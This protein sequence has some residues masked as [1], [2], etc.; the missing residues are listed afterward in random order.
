MV[1][2]GYSAVS[3]IS[4][5]YQYLLQ[6]LPHYIDEVE[7]VILG[8]D[9][10]RQ[11]WNGN[12]FVVP[13]K[14]FQQ[15]EAMDPAGKIRIVE[16]N[17]YIPNFTALENDTRERNFLSN[18]VKP[19]NW[20]ISLDAD[21]VILNPAALKDYLASLS[22]TDVSVLAQAVTVF[23]RLPDAILI[24]SSKIKVGTFPIA[25][26]AVNSYIGARYT[27]QRKV[28]CPA[29]LVHYSWGRSEAELY[30]KLTNWGHSTHFDVESYFSLW[31]AI[32]GNNY[33]Y[34][35]NFH[36]IWPEEWVELI[37]VSEEEIGSLSFS[38]LHSHAPDLD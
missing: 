19:G 31:K 23:K 10:Y 24:A 13:D 2:I 15:L 18:F 17:F 5:D 33:R 9:K 16:D 20:I 22:D 35:R 25:T 28:I 3:L 34:L 29:K 27:Q 26:K 30:M 4:Y 36:P 1:A 8:L 14:F 6:S 32:D 38:A 21:E 11:T 7:E 12:K 37:K